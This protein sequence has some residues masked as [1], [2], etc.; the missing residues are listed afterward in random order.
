MKTGATR[1]WTWV[2]ALSWLLA[3]APSQE[4]PSEE[5]PQSQ[6]RQTSYL[7][8]LDAFETRL[9]NSGPSPQDYSDEEPP[10]GVQAVSYS[11]DGF[12]LKA[13]FALPERAAGE[14][15]PGIVYCHGG[16]A[17]GAGDFFDA[18]PFL[19]AGFAVMAPILR[20]E[21]GNPGDF[22]L[23]L[24]E[25]DDAAAAVRWLASQPAVDASRIYAF[26]HSVGGGVS[27]LLSLRA[28]VPVVHT[29]SSGGLYSREVFDDWS[30]YVPFDLGREEERDMRLLLGNQRWMQRPH[31]A[32]LGEE[33]GLVYAKRAADEEAASGPTE[34]VVEVLSG[35]HFSSLPVAIRS[36]LDVIAADGP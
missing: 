5:A 1:R 33:D 22:E 21:N 23:F 15:V 35:D 16:F 28:D 17:F 25:V 24:G 19:D 34:L 26:G 29:G 14:P 30:D 32:F 36:Y 3:C 31:F 8:R 12:S 2:I 11:S 10:E 13:W 6:T 7:E 9:E 27:A 20:G 4:T 18:Q